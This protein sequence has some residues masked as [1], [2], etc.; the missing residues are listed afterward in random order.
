M[1]QKQILREDRVKWMTVGQDVDT[2]IGK[3]EG[4]WSLRRWQ[5]TFI[6]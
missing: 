1:G 2:G 4:E 5:K 3:G 6:K